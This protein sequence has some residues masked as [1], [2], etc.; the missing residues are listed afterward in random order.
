MIGLSVFAWLLLA[1]MAFAQ[2]VWR[3][4]EEDR[5]IVALFMGTLFGIATVS[6]FQPHFFSANIVGGAFWLAYGLI[7]RA[8]HEQLGS[9]PARTRM[10]ELI[11]SS[12]G[13]RAPA[14]ANVVAELSRG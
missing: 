8:H 2:R 3:T 4:G 11:E 10:I 5:E 9:V 7:C 13:A 1:G 12:A 6:L 14:P